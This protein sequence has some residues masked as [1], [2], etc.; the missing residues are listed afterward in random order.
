MQFA[1]GAASALLTIVNSGK[2][3][4]GAFAHGTAQSGLASNVA[5]AN[6]F[7]QSPYSIGTATASMVNSGVVS[8]GADAKGVS[9]GIAFAG[10]LAR[11][12]VQDPSFGTFKA[13]LDNRG[14][15]LVTANASAIGGTSAFALA[16]AKA[17][18]VDAA[19]VVADVT[20]SGSLAAQAAA[21]D[22]GAAGSAVASAVG[23]SILAM[24]YFSATAAAGALDGT[25]ENTGKINVSAKVDSAHSGTVGATASGIRIS[26][27]RNN[28][29]VTNSG[30]IDVQAVTGHGGSASANGVRVIASPASLPSRASDLFTFTNDGGTIIAR[31]STDDGKTWQRGMAIDV[32]Q[33]SNPSV[34][35]L[36]GNGVIYGDIGLQ[37]G[38]Q[39]NVQS[40]TTY[41]DGIIDPAS[42]PAGGISSA[43]LDSGLA[44]V[45][46]LNIG[47]GGNLVLADPRSE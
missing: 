37:A 25:V 22:S 8:V 26:A 42:L 34:I 23:I 4:V 10:A 47:A 43:V 7:E 13:A 31:Q 32:S 27:T 15:I 12:I 44:G 20:N 5:L 24:N 30:T 33:A 28:L 2:V 18:V 29:V 16:S 39:V 36:L 41:F 46:T 9:R 21:I 6:G 14:E 1:Q 17:Y 35:N 11:G 3:A 45:G 40:G 19:N 38:D